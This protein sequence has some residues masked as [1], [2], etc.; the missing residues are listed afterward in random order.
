[1]KRH[2][3]IIIVLFGLLLSACSGAV[4]TTATPDDSTIDS[5][6]T[7][8]N[9]AAAVS[10]EVTPLNLDH[11]SAITLDFEVAL[12]THSVDLNYDLTAIG[13]L[14]ADNGEEVTPLRWD[15]PTDGG[16]HVSGVLS[17][18]TFE[19][20]TQSVTLVLSG[21]AGVSE[22]TFEWRTTN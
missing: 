14:R 11:P 18:P 15:G 9:E 22:R 1:M 8:T 6:L 10:V 19:A 3:P 12:N 7:R 16:H 20:S 21:I 2:C 13:V 17:F 5:N 4:N